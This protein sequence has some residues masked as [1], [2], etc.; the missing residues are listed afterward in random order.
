[1][2]TPVEV[3]SVPEQAFCYQKKDLTSP[4]PLMALALSPGLYLS[5]TV[6]ERWVDGDGL[7]QMRWW[8]GEGMCGGVGLEEVVATEEP[9]RPAA[10]L[11]REER[12]R[13]RERGTHPE[14]SARHLQR[15]RSGGKTINGRDAMV[16]WRR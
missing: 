8:I 11:A 16:Q 15:R 2:D 14:D 13:E 12:E 4:L 6:K 7:G 1:M 9:V 5:E 10:S 3:A